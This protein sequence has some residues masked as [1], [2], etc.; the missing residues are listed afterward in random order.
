MK[1]RLRRRRNQRRWYQVSR[2]RKRSCNNVR[3]FSC[4]KLGE[5]PPT[6]A[7]FAV[8][9]EN[10]LRVTIADGVSRSF[11]PRDWARYVSNRINSV[12]ISQMIEQI[13]CLPKEFSMDS[14][15]GMSWPE[16]AVRDRY[17]SQTTVMSLEFKLNRKRQNIEIEAVGIGDCLMVIIGNKTADTP[18]VSWPFRSVQDFPQIPTSVCTLSP[19]IRGQVHGPFSFTTQND[20]VVLVM[21]DALGRY[22]LGGV[23]KGLKVEQLFPFLFSTGDFEDWALS[24]MRAGQVDEDDLTIMEVKAQ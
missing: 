21:T 24:A 8:S 15:E 6:N 23:A 22:F 18:V 14:I 1:N 9:S 4:A 2:T 19:H 17:G 3:I 13:A 20:D 5:N 11:R 12:P 10:G 7:D 16:Q